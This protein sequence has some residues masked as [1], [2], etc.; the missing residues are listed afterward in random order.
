MSK[1][2]KELMM[3]EEYLHLLPALKTL[4]IRYFGPD[5]PIPTVETPLL[6]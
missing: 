6:D 4:V 5:L 3:N 1:N 2:Y